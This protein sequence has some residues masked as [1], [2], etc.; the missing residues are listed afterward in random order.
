MRLHNLDADKSPKIHYP[1]VRIT[2][3]NSSQFDPGF[4][5][6]DARAVKRSKFILKLSTPASGVIMELWAAVQ[7]YETNDDNTITLDCQHPLVE[8][9]RRTIREGDAAK[10]NS[11]VIPA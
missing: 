5:Y 1:P 9:G 3:T 2:V 11:V 7:S 6:P 10:A 8:W 4:W